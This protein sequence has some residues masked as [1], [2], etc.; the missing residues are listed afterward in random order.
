MDQSIFYTEWCYKRGQ[1]IA[2]LS[3]VIVMIGVSHD[4]PHTSLHPLIYQRS[5]CTE[6][7]IYLRALLHRCLWIALAYLAC[8]LISCGGLRSLI[9]VLTIIIV[10][11]YAVRKS[12]VLYPHHCQGRLTMLPRPVIRCSVQVTTNIPLTSVAE[13]T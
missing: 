9:I 3:H 4:H 13:Q 11:P 7:P 2:C 6:L 8:S 12:E 5:S 1:R 10:L